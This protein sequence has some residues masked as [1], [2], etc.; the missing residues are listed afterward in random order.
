[1]NGKIVSPFADVANIMSAFS[2]NDYPII[3]LFDRIT[4]VAQ[5]K[6]KLEGG[7]IY[8]KALVGS[9]KNGNTFTIEGLHM[10]KLGNDLV[11]NM[12]EP[13]FNF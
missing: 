9:G 1:M 12:L 11:F 13:Y 10:N 7:N 8:S 6:A 3:N 2:S 4:E 5:E